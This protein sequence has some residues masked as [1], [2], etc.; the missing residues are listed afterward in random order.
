MASNWST[1]SIDSDVFY[2]E[3]S[4][5][6]QSPPR[7]NTPIV[8]NCTEKSGNDTRETISMSSIASP[9]PHIV[10]IDSDSNETPKPYGFGRQLPCI[11][12][13]LN[14]LNLPPNQFK[15]LATTA[16]VNPAE[17]DY[18]ENY[19]PQSPEPSEPSPISTPPMN[20]NSIDG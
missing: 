18:D 17:H 15:S 13:N 1:N 12:P 3:Q 8:L 20:I 10:T 9:D 11:S 2:V 7:P 6:D 16:V 4:S 14:D 19:S 5:S